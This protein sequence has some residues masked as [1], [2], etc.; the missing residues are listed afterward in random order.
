MTEYL[1][2]NVICTHMRPLREKGLS[3][4]NGITRICIFCGSSAG[5]NGLYMKTA[6]SVG[7][8]MAERGIG[9]VYGGG[10]IGL[11]GAAARAVIEAGGSV[12]GIIPR[13]LASKERAL[14]S[15]FE[16]RVE[17]KVVKT[18]HERKALMTQL[19]DAFIALPGGLGTF[20]ELFEALTWAQ[21]GIHRKPI[22]LLNIDGYF[23]PLLDMLNRA[24]G[25][26][27]IQPKYR[28][29]LLDSNRIE[30]LFEKLESY[31][32]PESIVQWIE[33]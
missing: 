32:P 33:N 9:L 18:M 14:E 5:S 6:M 27:F 24:T 26:G 2:Y 1:N 19:S 10:G 3:I 20:D 4:V 15:D 21:L 23:D 8:E 11:M 17:L 30:D 16:H 28:S 7:R 25:E 12:T 31:T 22:G 13:A 29:L